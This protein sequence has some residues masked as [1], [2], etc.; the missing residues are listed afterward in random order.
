ML[1]ALQTHYESLNTAGRLTLVRHTNLSYVNKIII[2]IWET[3]VRPFEIRAS[4]TT[5]IE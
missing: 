4:P 2:K 5:T 1:I 3:I